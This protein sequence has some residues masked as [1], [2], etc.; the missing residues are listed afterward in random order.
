ML[1]SYGV[2]TPGWWAFVVVFAGNKGNCIACKCLVVN[3][4]AVPLPSKILMLGSI[5]PGAFV[6]VV[7]W[8]YVSMVCCYL[9]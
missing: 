2:S 5:H 9:C 1:Q 4:M 3:T 7:D 8:V 6:F